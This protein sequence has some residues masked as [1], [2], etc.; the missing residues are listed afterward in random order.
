M[1]VQEAH[2]HFHDDMSWLWDKVQEMVVVLSRLKERPAEVETLAEA[3]R[4]EHVPQ[5]PPLPCTICTH[6]YTTC[7]M[8]IRD[9]IAKYDTTRP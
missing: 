8:A 2:Q 9:P 1:K 6:P 7:S 4:L 3:S 5:L